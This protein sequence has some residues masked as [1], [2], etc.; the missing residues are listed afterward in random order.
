MPLLCK[1]HQCDTLIVAVCWVITGPDKDAFRFSVRQ[2][3]QRG[4]LK[5]FF[6]FGLNHSGRL[7]F[8][9][10][11]KNLADRGSIFGILQRGA[12]FTVM[13]LPGNICQRMEMLLK[14]A[15]WH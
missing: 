11:A 10:L 4:S 9:R 13:K 1:P 5:A 8:N 6:N 14:L 3:S 2:D 7:L 12:K 15:L